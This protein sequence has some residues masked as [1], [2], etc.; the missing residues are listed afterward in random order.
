[1]LLFISPVSLSHFEKLAKNKDFYL[2]FT[3]SRSRE[4]EAFR[5]YCE[6]ASFCCAEG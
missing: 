3:F 1:M 4:C 5:F 6:S 2:E